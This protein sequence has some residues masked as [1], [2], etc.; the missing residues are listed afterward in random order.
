MDGGWWWMADGQDEGEDVVITIVYDWPAIP[1]LG[2]VGCAGTW[3]KKCA[4]CN[5]VTPR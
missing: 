1:K 4:V 5:K 3:N 2:S